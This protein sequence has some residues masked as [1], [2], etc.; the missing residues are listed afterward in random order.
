LLGAESIPD[1]WQ[2]FRFHNVPLAILIIF[3]QWIAF[4][5]SCL[6]N[7]K[8]S[9]HNEILCLATLMLYGKLGLVQA[10]F[11]KEWPNLLTVTQRFAKNIQAAVSS[12]SKWPP[13][14]TGSCPTLV[15]LTV[16]WFSRTPTVKSSSCWRRR[17][18][19][20]WKCW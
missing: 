1:F 19:D 15:V 12:I 5:P 2:P 17:Q 3:R 14:Q 11:P 7:L 6:P 9:D 10:R 20:L 8:S 13:Y 18:R 4:V 16:G